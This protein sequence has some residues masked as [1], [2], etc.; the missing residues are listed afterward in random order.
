MQKYTGNDIIELDGELSE[1]DY[2]D[3]VLNIPPYEYWM[4]QDMCSQRYE[5]LKQ[6]SA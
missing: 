6:K 4:L 3:Q 1:G 2:I 5:R